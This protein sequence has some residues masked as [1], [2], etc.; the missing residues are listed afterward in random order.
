MALWPTT[1]KAK[2]VV[3]RTPTFGDASVEDAAFIPSLRTDEIKSRYLSAV[4]AD[5]YTQQEWLEGCAAS[6]DKAYFIIEYQDEPIEAVRLYDA[7]KDS[8]YGGSWISRK[9]DHHTQPWSRR[10]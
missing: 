5:L 1:Q 8:F 9:A 3:G 6:Q 4:S 10:E 2:R 7:Q